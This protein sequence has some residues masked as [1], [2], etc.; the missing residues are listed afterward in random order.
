VRPLHV[1]RNMR[2]IVQTPFLAIL[3]CPRCGLVY[4]SPRPTP[5]DLSRFYDP[6]AEDGWE[7]GD[8]ID[9]PERA[10]ALEKMYATK[11][12]RARRML[13]HV[14]T[15]TPLP[16]GQGRHGLDFGCGAGAFLDVLQDAGWRTTGI[17]PHRL[18]EV[19]GRRHRIVDALPEAGEFDL[20]VLHHVLEHLLDP[21]VTLRDLAGAARPGALLVC[22][23]PDL[24]NLA[25]H[26]DLHYTIYS[27]HI[28]AFTASSL[29]EILRRAGWELRGAGSAAELPQAASKDA[30][31]LL[32]VA[33]RTTPADSAAAGAP[34]TMAE[35][36]LR[37]YGRR[38]DVNG[39]VRRT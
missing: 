14:A 1:A 28:N 12:E 6:D 35:D 39:K 17:E 21:A 22:S 27:V 8:G 30:T 38:L 37:A 11:R 24:G 29:G 16:D 7:R 25:A 36:A 20:I 34:L 23:V 13:E 10:A 19:A 26:G 18:R 3:G 4:S 2:P 5:D 15:W 33:R 9:D 32:A 31:R